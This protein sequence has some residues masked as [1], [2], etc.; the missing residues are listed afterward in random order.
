MIPNWD[1]GDGYIRPGFSDRRSDPITSAT[2]FI[3]GRRRFEHEGTSFFRSL[4]PALG[5]RRTPLINRYVYRYDF[6]FWPTG[7]LAEALDR[8]VDEVRGAANWDKLPD[9][10]LVLTMNTEACEPASWSPT[11]AAPLTF[12][13]DGWDFLLSTTNIN[14]RIDSVFVFVVPVQLE[15]HV[16]PS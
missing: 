8:P 9:K 7:G 6:G 16:A 14:E 2:M 10:E 15:E 12:D 1:Y 13:G 11:G 3:S 5:S 4:I